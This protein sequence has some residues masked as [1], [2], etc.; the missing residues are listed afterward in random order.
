MEKIL[1]FTVKFVF[2]LQVILRYIDYGKTEKVPKNRVNCIPHDMNDL[3]PLVS[4]T[5]LSSFVF[6]SSLTT[7]LCPVA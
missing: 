4:D 5:Y 2:S 1:L 3:Q 7:S 6:Q